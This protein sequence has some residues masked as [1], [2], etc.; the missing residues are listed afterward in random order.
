MKIEL[1][2]KNCNESFM[3][4]F[5]F[6]DKSFCN[7]KCY[8]E[9]ANENKL[10]GNKKNES[11]R[12]KRICVQCGDEFLER[13]KY[14]RKLCSE[15]CRK[16]WNI[17]EDNKNDRIK[18]SK[19]S[20]INKYGVDCHFKTNDFKLNVKNLMFE[21][22]GVYHPMEKK[23]FVDKLKNTFRE[24]H[25]P[26]LIQEL[27]IN[28]IEL[29]DD[30]INNKDKN[31][32][33]TYNFKCLKCDN[34][35][36]S[37]LL[38]SGKIPICRKCY[39]IIKNSSIEVFIKDLLNENQITHVDGNR[40]I[41]NGKEIDILIKEKN[42]GLEINGNYYHSEI[43]GEKDKN[44]HINK[45]KICYD[46]NIKLI[47]IYEDEIMLKFPIVKS[48]IKNILGISENKIYGRKC[49]V[50]EIDKKTA[51]NFLDKNHIQGNCV[52][53]IRLGLFY[54]NTLVSIMTFS[55]KRKVLGNKSAINEFELIRFCNII[56]SNVIGSFSK[57]LNY[58]INNFS[59]NKII[60]YADI[61]WSGLNPESTIYKKYGFKFIGTTPPNYWYLNRENYLNRY[62]RFNFRKDILLKEG[63][64]KIQTEWEIMKLKNYDRIWDCG[65][66]K[67]ELNLL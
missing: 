63:F 56:D 48:R 61:R 29:I 36:S 17:T 11:V 57:L 5:K 21:K 9:Y 28:N 42:I 19:E 3:T 41:L 32:S 12:E 39:P 20:M 53:K 44:Y 4:D 62:H 15:K 60:T 49:I 2:C 13:K 31:T 33:R 65:S 52:D 43:S 6:R 26:K 24:N 58:F 64:N 40:K 37:T 66:M 27:K 67:F 18:K 22:H 45:S 34:I 38:G 55:N 51:S 7:R 50:K 25:L 59:P 47:H 54:E 14:E 8:F 16:E 1:K 35:F 10:L 23:E 46:N 30:Y